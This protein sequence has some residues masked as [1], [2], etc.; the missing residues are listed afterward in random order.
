MTALLQRIRGSFAGAT[1]DAGCGDGETGRRMVEAMTGLSLLV[2]LDRDHAALDEARDQFV[3]LGDA[4]ACQYIAGDVTAL[5]MA[6][7]QFDTVLLNDVLHHTGVPQRAVRECARVLKPG[8]T[9]IVSE[10]V[11]DGLTAAEQVGRD[12][13]HLKS[14]IDRLHGIP[15]GPTLPRHCVEQM[16]ASAGLRTEWSELERSAPDDPR[17]DAGREGVA[18]RLDFLETYLEH[19]DGSETYAGLRREAVFL[20]FRMERVGFALA[21]ELRIVAVKPHAR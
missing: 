10:M 9:L 8:G 4:V 18:A 7:G 16:L 13:H 17:T 3:G 11:C 20:R 21:P 12:L 19:A 5:P 6:A 14:A 1:L 15:H 2:L